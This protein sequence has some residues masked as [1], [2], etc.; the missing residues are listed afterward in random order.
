MYVYGM[1]DRTQ[2]WWMPCVYAH[3][4]I[5]STAVSRMF[6]DDINDDVNDPEVVGAICRFCP[7]FVLCPNVH[8]EEQR[9]DLLFVL[10]SI[11]GILVLSCPTISCSSI[12]I[13]YINGLEG[14]GERSIL[15]I[16]IDR[17]YPFFFFVVVPC[18]NKRTSIFY[19]L[20]VSFVWYFGCI[21][22]F[23]T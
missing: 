14:H 1:Y 12:L 10:V 20:N 7:F 16:C 13:L 4:T 5:M 19:V 17:S 9:L 23:C 22:S 18:P 6:S 21:L 8:I 15:Y 3:N 2:K 11:Y